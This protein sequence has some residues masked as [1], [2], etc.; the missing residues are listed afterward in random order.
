MVIGIE[1]GLLCGA[2]EESRGD[3]AGYKG[4]IM[5]EYVVGYQGPEFGCSAGKD[6][7]AER[8]TYCRD[9]RSH[10]YNTSHRRNTCASPGAMA[11]SFIAVASLK[12]HAVNS[13]C[14]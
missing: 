2:Q 9:S 3:V 4:A 10:L 5:D 11:L 1:R 12:C 7:L 13:S 8:V 14:P 6:N